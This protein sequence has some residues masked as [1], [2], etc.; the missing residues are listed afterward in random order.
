M[1]QLFDALPTQPDAALVNIIPAG[2]NKFRFLFVWPGTSPLMTYDRVGS[3]FLERFVAFAKQMKPLAAGYCLEANSMFFGS[4]TYGQ[5]PVNVAY[6]DLGVYYQFGWQ[7][8]CRGVY[9]KAA[10]MEKPADGASHR[11][12]A[13]LPV[14]AP[15]LPAKEPQTPS[16]QLTPF[17]GAPAATPP[18]Q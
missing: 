17:L 14:P 11:K 16:E 6:R 10:D 15:S 9:I 1:N 3:S 4:T 8:P 7:P 18:L 2:P 5:Q 13:A 12:G